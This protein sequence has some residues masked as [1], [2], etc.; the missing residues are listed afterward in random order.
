MVHVHISDKNNLRVSKSL[1]FLYGPGY[2][3]YF[4]SELRSTF[5]YY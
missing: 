5:Y 2:T 3:E 4:V 1:Y